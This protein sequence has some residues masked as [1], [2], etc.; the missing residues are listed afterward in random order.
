[1]KLFRVCPGK[2]LH[3]PPEVERV[4]QAWLGPGGVI[5][6]S[7]EFVAECVKGQEFKLEPE[8]EKKVPD[9]FTSGR[10]VKLRDAYIAAGKAA[11]EAAPRIEPE[12]ANDIPSPDVRPRK[13]KEKQ[14]ASVSGP[15]SSIHP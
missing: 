14:D 15:V 3:Y 10:F 2:F 4:D 7:D 12:Q 1:M 6:L 5:D 8:T 9:P 11:A 13:G